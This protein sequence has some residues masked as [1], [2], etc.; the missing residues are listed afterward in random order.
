MNCLWTSQTD[1]KKIPPL[2]KIQ[3]KLP[4]CQKHNVTHAECRLYD[5]AFL[6]CH[7]HN[8]VP[9]REVET[10]HWWFNG[11]RLQVTG[12]EFPFTV[13]SATTGLYTC[14]VVLADGST[15]TSANSLHITPLTDHCFD[16]SFCKFYTKKACYDKGYIDKGLVR[17]TV[18]CP[19]LC[20]LCGN[21][22]DS[23]I[24]LYNDT[25]LH[26]N[27]EVLLLCVARPP[28]PPFGYTWFHNGKR[29]DTS[30]NFLELR[31]TKKSLGEYFC[32]ANNLEQ[33][34]VVDTMSL[35]C[36]CMYPQQNCSRIFVSRK[37]KR[38]EIKSTRNSRENSSDE[39]FASRLLV[40]L[41]IIR[42]C[43]SEFI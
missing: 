12:H 27:D 25:S 33:S 1:S 3:K 29:L 18:Q 13:T 26:L 35:S 5:K 9:G 10:K 22:T 24:D 34:R 20:G 41:V 7:V 39:G 14:D 40:A 17:L 38:W 37:K 42:A 23:Y 16:E 36:C 11:T 6:N 19:V 2:S 21:F 28:Q 30:V 43:V 15:L 4:N 31:V 8:I 32:S